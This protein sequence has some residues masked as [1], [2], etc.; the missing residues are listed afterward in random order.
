MGKSQRAGRGF[1][2]KKNIKKTFLKR[3][4]GMGGAQEK[5]LITDKKGQENT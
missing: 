5:G 3:G 4:G 1:T 2:K